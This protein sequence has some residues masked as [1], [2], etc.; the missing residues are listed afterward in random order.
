LHTERDNTV[1]QTDSKK[2]VSSECKKVVIAAHTFETEYLGPDVSNRGLN[3][4]SRL[5][6]DPTRE[7]IVIWD[8]K[9]P[10]IKFS[11]GVDWE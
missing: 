1:H 5:L 4:T 2:G 8:R 9:S 11:V 7:C 6:V 3:I 10:A